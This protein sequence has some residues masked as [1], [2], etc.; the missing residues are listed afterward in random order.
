VR[1]FAFGFSTAMREQHLCSHIDLYKTNA[2]FLF[3]SMM[4]IFFLHLYGLSLHPWFPLSKHRLS[5]LAN[6]HTHTSRLLEAEDFECNRLA[7]SL[8]IT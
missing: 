2:N 7:C 6:T 5:M 1:A 3:A 4:P 8:G